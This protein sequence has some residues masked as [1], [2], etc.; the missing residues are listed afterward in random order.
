MMKNSADNIDYFNLY[1]QKVKEI[2]FSEPHIAG[3]I[4]YLLVNGHIEATPEHLELMGETEFSL[5]A[6][7]LPKH[8]LEE[9]EKHYKQFPDEGEYVEECEIEHLRAE[10]HHITRARICN[11]KMVQFE[12]DVTRVAK[13]ETT[14]TY[15][16]P[17]EWK[18]SDEPM[19]DNG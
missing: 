1:L 2:G 8:M 11:G 17:E 7:Y 3:I 13:L 15:E 16:E 19:G 10:G 5:D 18:K 12:V 14:Y 9:A 6:K 4:R